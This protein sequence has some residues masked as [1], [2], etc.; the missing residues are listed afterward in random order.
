MRDQR[1]ESGPIGIG[2][3]RSGYGNPLKVLHLSQ[4]LAVTVGDVFR[5]ALRARG[6]LKVD[7]QAPPGRL[8]QHREVRE[9]SDGPP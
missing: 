5:D 8:R 2:A 7:N 9:H 6:L 3:I 1:N 4:P